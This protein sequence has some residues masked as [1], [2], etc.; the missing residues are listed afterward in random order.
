MK[1][2]TIISILLISNINFS[3]NFFYSFEN[4]FSGWDTT[5]IDL[6]LGDTTIAW[7]IHPSTELA[8]DS[9]YSMRYFLENYNDAGKIWIQKLFQVQQQKD[10]AVTIDYK[11]A[12]RDFGM[13]NLWTLI[14]GVHNTPPKTVD[15]LKYQDHT[16]NGFEFD[17][18]FVWLN[19]HYEFKIN[20]DTSNNLWIV[21]G[22][23]G[24]WETPRTYYID[25]L[26]I[27]FQE[28]TLS[29]VKVKSN[30]FS[31]KLYQNCTNPFN[32][33]TQISWQSPVS[34]WQ[35]EFIFTSFKLI[36]PNQVRER[37]LLKQRRWY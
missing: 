11:F 3:Q 16:G 35:A 15:E 10:Y 7:S 9:S 26:S 5:G 30:I 21:V 19:K 13:A 2:L 18:G 32:P 27:H 6:Q 1:K 28:D 25:S 4:T 37:F 8:M 12:S 23:W 33:S 17:V 34:S 20:S 22:I 14:T 29:S 36:I 31:H 24:N